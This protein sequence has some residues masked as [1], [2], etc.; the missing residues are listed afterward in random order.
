MNPHNAPSVIYPLGR[1]RFLGGILLAGWLLSAGVIGLWLQAAASGWRAP[2]GGLSLL[3]A[4]ALMVTAWRR[5]P[6]GYL[7]WTGQHWRW[8]SGVYRGGTAQDPP[9]VVLDWQRA[10]LLRLDNPA[11]AAWWLWAERSA[12][13]ARWL[14]LRRAVHARVRDEVTQDEAIAA[15]QGED[16]T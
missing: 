7:H 1:S 13:P 10:L 5:A 14:D 6:V 11:G 2:L 9:V 12:E 16:R 4:G 3:L 15:V 8:E